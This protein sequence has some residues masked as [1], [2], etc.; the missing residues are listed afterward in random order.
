MFIK[1][2]TQ[3]IKFKGFNLKKGFYCGKDEKGIFATSGW[4]CNNNVFIYRLNNG[5][6]EGDWEEVCEPGHFPNR[7]AIIDYLFVR[8]ENYINEDGEQNIRFI[9]AWELYVNSNVLIA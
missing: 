1:K 9:P 6:W 8:E 4:F 3:N 2:V 7:T 5:K